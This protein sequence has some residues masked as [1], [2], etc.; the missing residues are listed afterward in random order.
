MY[1]CRAISAPGAKPVLVSGVDVVTVVIDGRHPHEATRH[2][3]GQR[4]VVHVGA[5]L[6]RVRARAD[7]VSHSAGAVGVYRHFF[8]Q[9]VGG[10]DNRS[11]LVE[12]DRLRAVHVL[13]SAARSKDLDPVGP[14]LDPI[15]D[16]LAHRVRIGLRALACREAR[17]RS[18]DARAHHRARS[19]QLAHGEVGICRRIEIA[20]RGHAGLE[21]PP[22]VVLREVNRDRGQSPLPARTRARRAVPEV[23]DMRVQVDQSGQPGV[24]AEVH[25]RRAGRHVASHFHDPR[26]VDDD[27]RVI[28]HTAAVP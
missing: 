20:H 24:A 27:D 16:E 7:R 17:A 2:H 10:L 22:R 14:R 3:V 26:A 9:A 1:S 12:R 6:D 11:H 18:D 15:L 5:V 19:R 4:L 21:R 23:G 28:Y 13:E 8:A 25:H